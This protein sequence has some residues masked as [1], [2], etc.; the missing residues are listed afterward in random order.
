MWHANVMERIYHT[1]PVKK[2]SA[3]HSADCTDKRRSGRPLHVIH[4]A[5]KDRQKG[6]NVFTVTHLTLPLTLPHNQ[7]IAQATHIGIPLKRFLVKLLYSST[8]VRVV[9]NPCSFD[10]HISVPKAAVKL[11]DSRGRRT[12]PVYGK[13]T[14]TQ[15]NLTPV[16]KMTY[17]L[18]PFAT[19]PP[20]STMHH[21]A[22]TCTGL[23]P[24]APTILITPT[25]L[26]P[27]G[28][29]QFSDRHILHHGVDAQSITL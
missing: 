8:G 3:A 27:P 18:S 13:S 15:M 25:L 11:I 10:T 2:K 22:T 12:K 29:N 21:L 23:I 19:H 26:N 4:P 20:H 14:L 16:F 28:S 1:L 5:E 24:N 17:I 6:L 9:D 7:S